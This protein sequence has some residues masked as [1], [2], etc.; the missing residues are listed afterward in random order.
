MPVD[1]YGHDKGSI[2]LENMQKRTTTYQKNDSLDQLLAELSQLLTPVE[3]IVEANI[4]CPALP[5]LFVVGNPRSGTTLLMQFL[6][7]TGQFAVPTNLLSR[8]YYAPYLGGK[9]QQLLTDSRFDYKNEMTDLTGSPAY[10]SKLGKTVGALSPSEFNHFWRRFL[11]NYDPEYLSEDRCS[12]VDG[13]G[14]RR[15]VAAI[16]KVFEQPFAAKAVIL[17]YNLD[18]LFHLFKNC[19]VVYIE[20][21]PLHIMQ[22]ILFA[23][24]EF[25]GNRDIWWS[26]KP[27]EY[28]MLKD[29]DIYHQIAGQVYFTKLSIENSFNHIPANN[30][31]VVNYE[32]LCHEPKSMYVQIADKYS[33]LG[34]KLSNRYTG[35]NSFKVSHQIKLSKQEVSSFESAYGYF[36]NELSAKEP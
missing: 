20:R 25:Y 3:K 7:S 33:L 15:G 31:L 1:I 2:F 27:K 6:A 24:E 19:L 26:V 28:E 14:L 36:C 35:S 17:Q 13:D 11:P 4:I 18:L 9:I 8:F 10:T 22:S 23:R 21:S 29:M 32:T 16:E 30:Q 12:L 5:P 34:C